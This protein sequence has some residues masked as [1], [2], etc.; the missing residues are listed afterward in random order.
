MKYTE[1]HKIIIA[2]GW[3]LIPGRGKGGHRMYMKNGLVYPVPY[4]GS[5]EIQNYFA[6]KILK[7]MGI[8]K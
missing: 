1:L 3:V 4:H 7:E 2:N 5:A 8:D 6:K